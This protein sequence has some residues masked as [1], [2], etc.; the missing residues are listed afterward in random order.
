MPTTTPTAADQQETLSMMIA[1]VRDFS[2]REIAPYVRKWDEEQQLPD[3][4]FRSLGELGLMGM[5]VPSRYGGSGMDYRF[6]TAAIKEIAK[7]DPSVALSVAAHNSLCVGHINAF[8]TE[9]QK[10]KYLPRLCS[11]DCLGAWAL[12]EPG[13]GSDAS[14]LKT[15]ATRR[16]TSWHLQGAKQFITHGNSADVVVVLAKTD[17]SQEGSGPTAFI[18]ERGTKGL[19]KGRKEDKLGTRASETTELILEDCVISEEQIL[20]KEGEGFKNALHIL[21]GGRLSIAALALGISEGAYQVA[22]NY[23]KERKQF[24]KPIAEFQGIAFKLTNMYMEIQASEVLLES[25]VA[26]KEAGQSTVQHSSMA[27]YYASEKA[28]R[29]A[30][31]SVQILGGYGYIKEFP[32]E[33]FYR[34]SKICTIGEGTSEIQKIIISRELLKA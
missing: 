19:K 31:E 23:A 11:G 7:V 30:E 2:K 34:D 12:T 27:K 10:Q 29:I 9:E 14:A 13:S 3:E 28:V 5:L 22:L 1:S 21:D 24:G 16:A 17:S 4:L 6:Y 18:V 33:K 32:V 25:A 8:G 26:L 20:G 15:L